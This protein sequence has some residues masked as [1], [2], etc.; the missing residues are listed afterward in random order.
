MKPKPSGSSGDANLVHAGHHHEEASG[1]GEVAGEGWAL[2]AHAFL[3]DLDN[4]LLAFF[5]AFLDRGSALAWSLLAD[6]FGFVIAL[7][8]VLRVQVRDVEEA[9]LFG[10]EVDEGGLDGGLDV[11]DASDIDVADAADLVGGFDHELF[12]LA[13]LDHRDAALFAGYV[14]DD[15]LGV[16]AVGAGGFPVVFILG[17]IGIIGFGCAS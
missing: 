8:K 14:V 16:R 13:V 5:E 2:G 6:A 11:G 3:E 4:D 9:V 17:I 12:E 10:A 1:D 7:G 15:H